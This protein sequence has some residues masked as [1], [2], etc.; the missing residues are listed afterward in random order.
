M[1]IKIIAL[2]T[3]L[4]AF[5]SCKDKKVI[6][7]PTPP[8]VV[9][10][11]AA[12]TTT[13][14]QQASFTMGVAI[15][16]DL[17]KNNAAYAG[18][19]K[20]EFDRVTFEYQMKHGAN[21]LNNGSFDFTRTDELVNIMQAAGVEVYGHTLAWHQNNNGNYLRSLTSATGA[22]LILNGSFENDFT[23]WF[24]QVSTTAPTAGA[25]TIETAG[26]QAGA[27]AARVLVT[28][29]GPNA[30]SIQLVGDNITLNT[31][32]TY[33][34]K[35]WAKAAVAGQTFRVVAQGTGTYYQQIEQALTT[36]WAE[37][38]FPFTP[39]EAAVSIKYHFPT[40]GNFLID[41]I[42]VQAP[43]SGLDQ[44]LVSNALQTWITA[45]VG[46]NK[47]KIKAW[48]VVNEAFEENG[49]IRS[50][51]NSGD[52]FFWAPILGRSYIANSF[53]WA[54]AADPN[55][56]L[57]LNDYNLEYAPQKLDSFVSMANE[58]KAQ[59]VP[60]HG[61]ATQMHININ[62]SNASIDN[63]FSKMAA[64]GL[65]I[66]VSELDIRINPNDTPGFTATTDLLNQQAQKYKYVAESYIKNVPAAQRYGI[67]IWNVTDADS[68]IVTSLN[69]I[70]FPTLF[71]SGFA[72]KPAY[73]SF[74]QALQ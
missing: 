33:T 54:N 61:L 49:R 71:T 44:T 1:K 47:G 60:I 19:V 42:S 14:K 69:K 52:V 28:T 7:P 2:S 32:T 56:L 11:P 50:G 3:I 21:V 27:K 51:T 72:K 46:R 9:V 4:I 66:H 22:N 38:S 30:Y 23:N 70:D 16:Y 29:P 55:A 73:N 8:V 64:T 40:A 62:T 34:L 20:K 24:T 74:K 37:Y 18:L 57:F 25:I 26:A 63:M 53:K 31:G 65:K 35:Y 59:A 45:M 41:N 6:P 68:W 13:L 5:F 10:P 12:D 43:G 39:T 58:L 15:N 36:T 67:T 17:M 48:D